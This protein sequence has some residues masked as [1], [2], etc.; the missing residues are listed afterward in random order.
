MV[1]MKSHNER[2]AD[3]KQIVRAFLSGRLVVSI[4]TSVLRILDD[5]QG[6]KANVSK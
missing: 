3:I 4:M 5:D 2:V 6:Q 1:Q